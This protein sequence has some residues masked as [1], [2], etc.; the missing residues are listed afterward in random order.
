MSYIGVMGALDALVGIYLLF[1]ITNLA[2]EDKERINLYWKSTTLIMVA[3]LVVFLAWAILEVGKALFS[4]PEWVYVI[5]R[6]VIPQFFLIIILYFIYVFAKMDVSHLL[7]KIVPDRFVVT[8]LAICVYWI[9]SL[10]LVQDFPVISGILFKSMDVVF[11]ISIVVLLYILYVTLSKYLPYLKGGIIIVP[12]NLVDIINGFTLAFVLYGFS[13]INI[14]LVMV[15]SYKFMEIAAL[16]VFAYNGNNYL[17][18]LVKMV[19]G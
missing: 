10:R 3:S 14:D 12:I 9:F 18:E 1:I 6:V 8:L 11:A 5:E 13:L 19:G 7:P 4:L 2:E 16:I 17:R 15:G